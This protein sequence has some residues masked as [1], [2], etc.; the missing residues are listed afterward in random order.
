MPPDSNG[1]VQIQP[2]V[3][4]SVACSALHV[5]DLKTAQAQSH[6]WQKYVWEECHRELKASFSFSMTVLPQAEQTAIMVLFSDHALSDGF[7]GYD[8]CCTAQFCACCHRHCTIRPTAERARAVSSDYTAVTCVAAFH[9]GH[10]TQAND[11]AASIQ[12]KY[13]L[14]G[15]RRIQARFGFLPIHPLSPAYFKGPKREKEYL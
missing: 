2:H 11:P 6:P 1:M 12:S 5:M 8:L 7:S 9:H 4:D 14:G 13:C 10:V 15:S 3:S